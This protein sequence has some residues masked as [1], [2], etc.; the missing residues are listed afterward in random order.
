MLSIDDKK[1]VVQACRPR[2]ASSLARRLIFFYAK[3]P[4]MGIK[5]LAKLLSDEAPEVS[6]ILVV[7]AR[8]DILAA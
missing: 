3:A 6:N 8:C 4:T 5:G 1:K 2:V 7:C